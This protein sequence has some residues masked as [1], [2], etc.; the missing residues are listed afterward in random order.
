M[1]FLLLH[2]YTDF[3]KICE[4]TE[5]DCLVTDTRPDEKF[6][7]QLAQAGVTLIVADE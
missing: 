7:E 3:I 4:L 6:C 2:N 5:I 1:A